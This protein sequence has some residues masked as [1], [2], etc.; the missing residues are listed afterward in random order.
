MDTFTHGFLGLA[1][2]WAAGGAPNREQTPAGA[3]ARALPW[4]AFMA[5]EAPDLDVLIRRL[6]GLEWVGHRGITHT[7]VAAPILALL[8]T[9]AVKAV[10]R[11]AR[12]AILYATSLGTLLVA[13][14]LM[15]VITYRGIRPWLPWSQARLTY[16]IITFIDLRVSLP[17]AAATLIGWYRPQWRRQVS[18][19][20]LAWVGLY[21]SFRAWV[22]LT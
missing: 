6:P 21:L 19:A 13:H 15:D 3:T 16:P 11:Q 7:F 18:L 12:V 8:I 10:F 22:Y 17:L 1:V 20:V 4:V 9:V 5:A 2:G 14:L